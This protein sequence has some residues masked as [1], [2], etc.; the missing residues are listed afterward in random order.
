MRICVVGANSAIATYYMASRHWCGDQILQIRR[1]MGDDEWAGLVFDYMVTFTGSVRNTKLENMPACHW[2]TVLADTLTS[3]ASA[4]ARGLPRMRDGGSIVVVGSIVGSTGGF[5]CAIYAAAKAGLV[6]LVRAAA[7]ETVKRNIRINLLELGYTNIG[8]GERLDPD[9]KEQIIQSIP[10]KRFAEA[11]EVIE[12]INFL[13]RQTYM[14]GNVLT[15]AG[16]LH[17]VS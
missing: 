14:T 17:G 8:M 7:N 1:G 15:F 13:N 16:G 5:G 2:D 3:V 11:G 4:L 6:G 9:I 10:M 12:V